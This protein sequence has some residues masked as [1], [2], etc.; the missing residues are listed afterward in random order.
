ML[1]EF[2]NRYLARSNHKFDSNSEIRLFRA[3]VNQN[4]YQKNNSINTI[5][6]F[7][8]AICQSIITF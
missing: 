6:Q 7:D 8:V 3:I 2:L 4:L 5:C 1:H